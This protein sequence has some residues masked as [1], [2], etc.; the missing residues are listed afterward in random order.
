MK[1]KIL[2]NNCLQLTEVES[3]LTLV[4]L[5]RELETK[6]WL[7]VNDGLIAVKCIDAI[8]EVKQEEK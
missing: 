4:G 3:E 2:T 1:Y 5:Q 8:V 7:R 6:Q